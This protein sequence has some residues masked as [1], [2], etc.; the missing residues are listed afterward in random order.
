VNA[1]TVRGALGAF[2]KRQGPDVYDRFFA[3]RNMPGAGPS[4]LT[5]PP[6]PF[7]I[8]IHGPKEIGVH[9]FMTRDGEGTRAV[10]LFH[11]AM[12]EL[13]RIEQV[14]GTE[15]LNLS[16]A[17]LSRPVSRIQVRFVTPAELK[18][19]DR[20][21]FGVLLARIR[22]RISTLLAFYGPGPLAMDFRAFAGRAQRVRMTRC[23]L[24]YVT[25]A[26]ISRAT[27]QRHP[28]GGFTGVAEYEGELAEFVPFLEVAQWVGAGR[29]TVWG[30]GEIVAEEIPDQRA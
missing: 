18:G 7:V 20:P 16:L 26:R 8:R 12:A 2:F 6:R 29:Q 22:D 5:D 15:L 4:G 11:A 30:K 25:A 1:N 9:V 10:E 13:G 24:R 3:P 17:P 19:A 28:L 23:D 21:E 27:G 14:T